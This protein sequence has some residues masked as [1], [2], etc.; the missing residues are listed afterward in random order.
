MFFCIHHV[1]N[2]GTYLDAVVAHKFIKAGRVGLTLLTR[3][4]LLI[5]TVEDA[6]V[7]VINAVA[8]KDIG[9]ELQDCGLAHA[10]LSNKKDGVWFSKPI[11]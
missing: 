11:V 8:D 9:D 6:E 5:A 4:T 2:A 7:V 1:Q 3:T 10:S